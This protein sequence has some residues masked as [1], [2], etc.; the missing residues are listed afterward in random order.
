MDTETIIRGK[1]RVGYLRGLD[2]ESKYLTNNGS[3]IINNEHIGP[4]RRLNQ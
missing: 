3:E 1:V 2:T 4:V